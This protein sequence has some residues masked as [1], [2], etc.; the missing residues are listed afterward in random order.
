MDVGAVDGTTVGP[1]QTTWDY[2]VKVIASGTLAKVGTFGKFANNPQL[3]DW[4]KRHG[5]E[6]FQDEGSGN[7]L[8]L[9]VGKA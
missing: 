4:A 8:H 9:Q 2:L 1:N 3:Q 5:V 7:H 6:L